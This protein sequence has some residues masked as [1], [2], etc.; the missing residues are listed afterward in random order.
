MVTAN[1]AGRSRRRWV[2]VIAVPVVV[3]AALAHP[4]A[5]FAAAI[6]V[7]MGG[8]RLRRMRIR[9][10]SRAQASGMADGLQTLVG[11]LRVGA[12]PIRAFDIAADESVGDVAAALRA[13][14]ARA[15]LGSDIA[16]GLRAAGAV[17]AAPVYWFRIEVCWRLAAEHGLPMSML[18]GAAQ[19]D[20][21]E[22]QR[23]ADRVDAGLAGARATATILACL[24]MVGV[25]LGQLIG[26]RPV[27][28][29]LGPG[30]WLLMVGV[31]LVCAGIGWSDRIIDRLGV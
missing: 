18:M 29:L 14:A 7:V 20:I 13:V 17:S 12:Q 23:F 3:G 8:M 16:A 1:V 9:R 25:V 22:R 28:F 19:R 26:A 11:E 30:G 2:G 27:Q 5:T 31:V 15:R 4:V 24:P 6:A 21:V 10:R